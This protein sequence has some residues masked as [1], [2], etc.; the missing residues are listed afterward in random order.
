MS[1]S[2][3]PL[4]DYQSTAVGNVIG[5][6]YERPILVA[7]TG[8]GKT[9]MGA[10]IVDQTGM[11][12]L[13]IAH[14]RELVE[15]AHNQL[16]ALGEDVGVIMSGEEANPFARIQVASVQTLARRQMPG[17]DL[18]VID[19]AHHATAETYSKVIDAQ[20]DA[21]VLGL[22]ATPYRLDGRGLGDVFGKLVVAAH[23]TELIEAGSLIR[24]R[25]FVPAMPDMSSAKKIGGDFNKQDLATTMDRPQ[26]VADVVEQWLRHAK[27]RRT[28]AFG[29]NVRHSENMAKAFVRAG[30]PAEH[31]DG[32]TDRNERV[33]ILERLRTGKTLVVSNCGIVSEGF[34]L[35]Q[36]C[37]AIIAQPTAS[38]ALHMQMV[39]RVMRPGK[40]D[41][42]VLDHAGNHIRHGSV[43]QRINYTL[44]G[45]IQTSRQGD[46][47]GRT[48]GEQV[49]SECSALVFGRPDHCPECGIEFAHDPEHAEG[50]L[51]EIKRRTFQDNLNTWLGI[52][53]ERVRF[54]HSAGWSFYR[55]VELVGEKPILDNDDKLVNVK[56]ATMGDKRSVHRRLTR[57]QRQRGF[58]SGWVAHQFRAIFG[59]WPRLPKGRISA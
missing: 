1:C 12:T 25:V 37:A 32:K 53:A 44:Q 57:V 59:V 17:F 30:I 54:G 45:K 51:V 50:E 9:V 19:E 23:S 13:W 48:I 52:E 11:R 7:P 21:C 31:L 56:K 39:G 16:S 34:D 33:A 24:P 35:P 41:A 27:G 10:A 20:P 14:R 4:R 40:T 43:E 49:C 36:L 46:D 26:L 38:L 8:S 28:V 29:V 2:L 3:P 47:K 6:M 5:S 18:V 55:Y 58:K 22:T 15:Q 42:V